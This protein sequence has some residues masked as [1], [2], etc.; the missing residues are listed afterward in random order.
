MRARGSRSSVLYIISMILNS[1]IM[2]KKLLIFGVIGFI[3]LT[4]C[5]TIIALNINSKHDVITFN[6]NT[7]FFQIEKVKGMWHFVDPEGNPFFST[8]ICGVTAIGIYAPD[9]G[10]SPYHENI[11]ELY[12]DEEAWAMVTHDRMVEWNFNTIGY[13][14]QYIVDT[15]LPYCVQLGLA[16]DD[17]IKG[18]IAD[19]FSD[20]WISEVDEMCKEKVA[21]ISE[22]KN[23]IGFFLDNEVHWGPDWRSL[24][25]L[26]EDYCLMPYDSPGKHA[27]VE[28]FRNRYNNDI[29]TFNDV[30]KKDYESF[31]DFRNATSLSL[32]ALNKQVRAD[33]A[34]FTFFVAEQFFKVCY[35]TIRKY[36]EKHLIL[37]VRFQSYLTPLEVVKASIPYVDVIS[38]NHYFARPSLLPFVKLLEELLGFVC[39]LDVLEEYYE[40]TGKPIL[41]SEFNIRAEDS[42]L[43]NTKPSPILFP[44][45]KTQDDRTDWFEYY[46]TRF[47][48]KPYSVGYHWFCYIDEPE[49]GRSDGE[50]SNTGIVNVNDE[51]YESLVN[52]MTEINKLAQEKVKKSVVVNKSRLLYYEH[53]KIHTQFF[54]ILKRIINPCK[55]FGYAA[56]GN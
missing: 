20:E 45:V 40:I 49:T 15:G 47:I 55:V 53:L 56:G 30:W 50:N 46:I 1:E 27:L 43:P 34:A 25:D 7:N 11:M 23:L 32:F 48:K 21:P 6:N 12:S 36:D 35:E 44:V 37:G 41:I 14:D 28:F 39:P 42:G 24:N 3:I 5:T 38:T 29:E 18:G 2:K 54:Q 19:Y 51:P 10:Y 8:G 33:R 26:A 22:D 13:G 4:N 31:D 52:R 17:W 9:L 16:C